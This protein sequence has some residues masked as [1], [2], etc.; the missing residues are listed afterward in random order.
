MKKFLALLLSVL[1]VASM[2]AGCA[3]E[4]KQT[5]DTTQTADTPDTTDTVEDTQNEETAETDSDA[6]QIELNYWS[7]WNEAEPQGAVINEAVAAFE[8]EHPN[9]KINVNWMGRDIIKVIATKLEA[10]EKIDLYDSPV[11]TLLPVSKQYALDLTP[12]YEKDYPTTNG[13]PYQ[14]VV[15]PAMT[16]VTKTYSN[17]N[18]INAVSYAPFIQCMFYNKDQFADAGIEK[19]PETWEEFLDC[20]EKLKAAGYAPLTADDAYMV[21]LPGMY[22]ARAKGSDWVSKLVTENSDEM[23]RDPAVLEMAQAYADMAEKGYFEENTVSNIF[24]AG[25]QSLAN[26]QAAMYLNASWVIN[27][28]MPVTG[29]DFPWG[30]FNFPMVP[31]GEG[32]TNSANYGQNAMCITK[33][34][35]HPDEAFE[36]AVFL[37]TGEMDSKYAAATYSVPCG[38]D[39]EWPVQLTDAKDVFLSVDEWCPWSGGMEDNADLIA[40][41]RT[42]FTELI[43]GQLTPEEFVERMVAM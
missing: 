1:L 39:S 6:E 29:E 35:E 41:I 37:T 33:S 11:N 19:L 4:Q 21:A 14:D 16:E 18:E 34:S 15:L 43:G 13:Q 12:Y 32:N 36:F 25:Q 28:L 5:T 7:M 38:I 31:N 42:A 9:V 17:E 20:C 8:A 27:E 24:P 2:M 3:S 30:Q 22:L 23:W 10:G 40:T 26:G